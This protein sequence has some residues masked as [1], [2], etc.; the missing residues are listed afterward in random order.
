[1]INTLDYYN[2]NSSFSKVFLYDNVS[3]LS[4][5]FLNFLFTQCNTYYLRPWVSSRPKMIFMFW[6]AWPDA[7]YTKLQTVDKAIILLCAC[8]LFAFVLIPD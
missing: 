4:T 8:L 6:I 3:L 2:L 7:R 1:M 5:F